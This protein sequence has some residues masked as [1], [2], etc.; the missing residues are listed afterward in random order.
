MKTQLACIPLLLALTAI[1]NR[2]AQ[3]QA[4]TVLWTYQ[5][6]GPLGPPSLA[7][8]GTVYLVAG[9]LAAITNSGST[10]S[11]KWS[12]PASG[13]PAVGADG[14]IYSVSGGLYAVT[15]AGSQKWIFPVVGANSLPAIGLDD[16]VYFLAEGRLYAIAGSGMERWDY[17][18]EHDSSYC[19]A[20]QSPVIGA[21]GT[22]YVGVAGTLYALTRDGTKKWTATLNFFGK[23][24]PAIGGGGLIYTSAEGL[25][26][27]DSTG[28]NL[29]Y[30]AIVGNSASLAVATDGT[31]YVAGTARRLRAVTPDGQF[32][33]ASS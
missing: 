25:Y 28:A 22:V 23:D 10:G 18:L 20:V 4:G 3:P 19:F 7:P 29:W 26:A 5:G 14:T 31:L 17:L 32:D 30:T 27:F 24:S 21:D 15:P 11:N 2:A 6:S 9:L 1:Q 8:D 33:L 12:F 13:A 16:T